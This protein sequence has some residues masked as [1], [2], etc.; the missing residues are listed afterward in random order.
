[1]KVFFCVAFCICCLHSFGQQNQ[2]LVFS[3]NQKSPISVRTDTLDMLVKL[4]MEM[5]VAAILCRAEIKVL[6]IATVVY[7]VNNMMDMLCL[8]TGVYQPRRGDPLRIFG[9]RPQGV[10]YIID[11]MQI[12]GR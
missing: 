9:C 8:N 10:L 1:M 11:G 7:P 4:P 6:P 2:S 5:R 12:A 3:E